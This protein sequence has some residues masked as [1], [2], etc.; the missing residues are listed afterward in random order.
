MGKK[1]IK[2]EIHFSCLY[3]WKSSG[4]MS[5][6]MLPSIEIFSMDDESIDRYFDIS[7]DWLFWSITFTT[8]WQKKDH[9]KYAYE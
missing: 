7:L 8:Y 5:F 3:K 1:K 4:M 2:F 9:R 6:Y